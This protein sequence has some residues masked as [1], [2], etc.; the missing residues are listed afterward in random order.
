[1]SVGDDSCSITS[2]SRDGYDRRVS[3]D[4]DVDFQMEEAGLRRLHI[5]DYTGRNDPYSP[6]ATAGQKRR[7]SSPPVDGG[8]SLHT[9]GSSSDLYRRRESVSRTS[10]SPRFHSLS[11]SISSTTSGPRSNSYASTLSI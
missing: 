3:P 1:M 7:A 9:V 2:R 4:N 11:G 10:P 6:G 8:P 5:E